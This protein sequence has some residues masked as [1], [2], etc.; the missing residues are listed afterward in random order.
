MKPGV[1]VNYISEPLA[2][3]AFNRQILLRV[4]K[5]DNL[6]SRNEPN[7][8]GRFDFIDGTTIN[9]RDGR[10]FF[11]QVEPF[12]KDLQ[13]TIMGGDTSSGNTVQGKIADKYIFEELYD[14]TQTK[15]RQISK[16]N[17][18]FLAGEFESS[19]SSEIQL[20]AMNVPQGSVKV[21]SGGI[22]LVEGQDYTVDYTLG[23]VK[24]LN[25]GLIESGAPLSVSLENNALFNLQTKSLIGTHLDYKF[26]DNFNVGGT[27]MHLTERPLTQKVNVGDEP[28][29]NTIWGLNTS[30]RTDSRML[31][32][33]IDKL[34]LI[35]T[36]ENSSISVDA[37]FAQ[38]IPGQAK[39]IGE[40]GVAYI[41]DFEGTETTVELKTIQ[42]WFLSSTPRKFRN[43]GLLNNLSYG[44]GR[45]K[46]AWYTIDPL[47]TRNES[48]TPK[49]ITEEEQN[50]P[51][52]REV[53][54][55]EIYKNRESGTGFQ[56]TLM[57]MNLSYY[58]EER[59][60]YNF[61]PTLTSEYKLPLPRTRWG[62]IMREI[63]TSDFETSNIEY[64]EF[65]LM[66]PFVK[67][68]TSSGGDLFFNLG[69]ISEDVLKDSRKSFENGLPT[70]DSIARVDTNSVWGRVPT[71]QSIVNSFDSDPNNR[72]LQDVGMDG[73]NDDQE[74]EKY[75]SFVNSYTPGSRHGKRSIPTLQG[76]ISFISWPRNMTIQPV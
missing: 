19:S 24:I 43:S 73:M 41:D 9:P 12:G 62:G 11:T 60:P 57:I 64:I 50:D 30:Y 2:D 33:W 53:L 20:N 56:N 25:Q 67:D 38:M 49:N 44:Y 4:M 39:I 45:S 31:T 75:N 14:S 21:S 68:S 74:R 5:M 69:E 76:M 37:E 27:V 26:S 55:T 46:L 63:Q 54:E 7:P 18:F 58:P 59:G 23:R 22:A 28:I 29:S 15:A 36:K 47:F 40:G 1:P 52:V 8:D 71:T 17:K 48:R 13:Y 65:W 6:D 61:D 42:S 32:K 70:S 72:E 35:E 16:K 66:D 3:S 10:V 34:P 51:Y